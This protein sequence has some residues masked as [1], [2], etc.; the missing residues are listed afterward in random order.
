MC[1]NP[2]TYTTP[3]QDT[4]REEILYENLWLVSHPGF[5]SC[6]AS[7]GKLLLRCDKPLTLKYYPVVFQQ[8]SAT[9][10]GLVFERGKK[11]YFI[12]KWIVKNTIKNGD[13]EFKML[14]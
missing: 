1:P 4:L 12:G 11:Y 2:A 6:D 14:I 9:P 10:S 8:F 3:V 5:D 7:S 13:I